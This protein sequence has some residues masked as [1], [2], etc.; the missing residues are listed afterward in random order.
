MSDSF[1]TENHLSPG[2]M[3]QFLEHVLISTISLNSEKEPLWVNQ[4]PVFAME[5]G[6][7]FSFQDRL[8][9]FVPYGAC[10]FFTALIYALGIKALFD[11]GG[12]AGRNYDHLATAVNTT[13]PSE[14][15]SDVKGEEAGH[16]SGEK[17]TMIH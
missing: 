11:N 2:T 3:Q 16:G 14:E 4:D 6:Q 8:Q 9:F 1:V 15:F 5:G 10:L 13:S 17:E 12:P 7:V